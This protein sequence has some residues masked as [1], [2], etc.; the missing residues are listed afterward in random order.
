MMSGDPTNVDPACEL[1]PLHEEFKA[2]A[3]VESDATPPSFVYRKLAGL[4][5]K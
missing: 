1:S 5:S 3:G 2:L 4:P